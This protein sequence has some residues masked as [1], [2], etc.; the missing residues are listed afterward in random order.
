MK[1]D[2]ITAGVFLVL[3]V[4]TYLA[5]MLEK[6]REGTRRP[7]PPV[8]IVMGCLGGGIGYLVGTFADD[9]L[10]SAI[11][12]FS[13]AGTARRGDTPSV[14][15]SLGE[16]ADRD[17]AGTGW[18]SRFPEEQEGDTGAWLRGLHGR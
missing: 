6:G 3:N 15:L 11:G 10:E 16:T 2:I 1:I 12:R 7:G 8:L 5:V 4:A 18:Y 9:W 13:G 14:T 17:P